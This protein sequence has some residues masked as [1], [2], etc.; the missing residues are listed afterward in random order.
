MSEQLSCQE[1]HLCPYGGSYKE[2][3]LDLIVTKLSAVL[4]A[5]V[6]KGHIALKD[7]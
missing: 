5:D 1:H 6:S 4:P 2:V 7:I 3:S